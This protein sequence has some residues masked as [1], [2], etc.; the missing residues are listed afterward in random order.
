M[1]KNLRKK[2]ILVSMC[3]TLLVL[4]AI[5]GAINIVSYR[6]IIAQADNI[7]EVLAENDGE[8]PLELR[9]DDT[10]MNQ[11]NKEYLLQRKDPPA[12]DDR[13]FSPETRYETRFFSVILNENGAVQESNLGQ[14]AS[15]QESDASEYAKTV[16]E[17]GKTKGFQANYRYLVYMQEESILIVF[18]DMGRE[19]SS[20]KTVLWM[21]ILVAVIG[22]LMVFILVVIFSRIVFR[23]VTE[24]FE[25]QK[26]FITDASHE[27]KTPLTIIDANT[28]V[29]EM[30]YGENE[31]TSS[32][33]KQIQR[34]ADLTG[35]L[36]TL[37]RMDEEQ[38][39]GVKVDFSISDAV[40]E[41]AEAFYPLSKTHEKKLDIQVQQGLTYHGDEKSIRQ[42]VSILLDNAVKY[43]SQQG[44][45]SL[46]LYKKGKNVI[47]E[48][49]NPADDLPTG[50][51]D[52][53][54]ERFYRL[55]AS[56]NSETGGSGIGLSVAKAIVNAHKG[57]IT[58]YSENGRELTVV[59]TLM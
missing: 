45:I 53:L 2:F 3:S 30:E 31:W 12:M 57:K 9:A 36:V 11:E 28:E 49:Q 10:P 33:R 8:F 7:L 40:Y 18:T 41:T 58:A 32:T 24:S 46:K 1:I 29:L 43:S 15:V 35:Q 55:D 52:M 17:S 47:L 5:L 34:L 22:L 13:F 26:R 51:L 56:R 38:I 50:R 59:V 4:T 14:I 37:T 16:Y 25:K 6:R 48:V 20:F 39:L 21:S 44:E 27:I 42:I 23:P 54:F 19:L